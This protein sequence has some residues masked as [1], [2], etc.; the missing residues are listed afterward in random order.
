MAI[1]VKTCMDCGEESTDTYPV[2]GGKSVRCR[3]CH[4][5]AIRRY[6]RTQ[7]DDQDMRA[8]S[9]VEYHGQMKRMRKP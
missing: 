2:R 9:V 5:D 8:N 1:P 4:E 6:Y 7:R 3:D